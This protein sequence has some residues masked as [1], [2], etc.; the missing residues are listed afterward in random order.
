MPVFIMWAIPAVIVVG[1]VGYYLVRAVHGRA[2][3]R[4]SSTRYCPRCWG[5]SWSTRAPLVKSGM[6]GKGPALMLCLEDDDGHIENG[7]SVVSPMTLGPS[8]LRNTPCPHR[9]GCLKSENCGSL[10]AEF[11]PEPNPLST[12]TF[13]LDQCPELDRL[14][15]CRL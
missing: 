1:G 10:F 2:A 14:F 4:D 11:A 3:K 5:P 13:I 15:E 8:P 12:A 7:L 6:S 9:R